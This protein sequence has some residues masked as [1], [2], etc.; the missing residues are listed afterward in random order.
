MLYSSVD[1]A[2]L[3]GWGREVWNILDLI[4]VE[5]E[6]VVLV[7]LFTMLSDLVKLRVAMLMWFEYDMMIS[8]LIR[9]SV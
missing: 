6:V 1:L 7:G 8:Q 5:V 3:G 9:Y 4:D 2:V